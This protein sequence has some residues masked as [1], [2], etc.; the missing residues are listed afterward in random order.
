MVDHADPFFGE[1]AQRQRP[2]LTRHRRA[3]ARIEHAA[4]HDELAAV[5]AELE[6]LCARRRALLDRL[7]TL[8]EELWPAD[9]RC[10]R[11]RRARV[12]EV[13]LPPAP[14]GA[15]ALGGVDLRA[16]CLGLLRRHGPCGLRELHGLLHRHGYRIDGP[17][18]VQGLADA[19][20]YEV[21]QGRAHRVARGVYGAMASA[22]EPPGS[23]PLPWEDPDEER[24]Q[25]D[26]I[27]LD[28]PERWSDGAWPDPPDRPGS[29]VR[30]PDRY[31][32][33]TLDE[34]VAR[35]RTRA[36]ALLDRDPDRPAAGDGD[37]TPDLAHPQD[38]HW[39]R[40]VDESVPT[41]RTWAVRRRRQAEAAAERER[42][43]A[44]EGGPSWLWG[45]DPGPGDR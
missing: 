2:P 30:P 41:V 31:D 40:F 16:T 9:Q 5:D 36:A 25:L 15:D 18:S 38:V 26:P 1:W 28:D 14:A 7:T 11:R 20:A 45:D 43:R 39:E 44:Q 42:R 17:R 3:S 22:P 35:A 27:V 12:D 23:D 32:P 21:R 33:S 4:L 8:R 10:H 24:P 19:M 6:V 29:Q 34:D 13:P 37:R